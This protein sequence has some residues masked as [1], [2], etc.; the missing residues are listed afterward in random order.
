MTL[1]KLVVLGDGGVG[2]TALTIQVCTQLITPFPVRWWWVALPKSLCGDV[3]SN[4]W[5]LLPK[6]GCNWFAFLYARGIGYGRARRIYGFKRPMDPRWRRICACLQHY[7]SLIVYENTQ[8]SQPDPAGEGVI[9]HQLSHQRRLSFI[10]DLANDGRKLW[11]GAGDVGRK[12]KWPSDGSSGVLSGGEC[13]SQRHGLRFCR[14]I[15]EELHQRRKSILRSGP[16]V[17]TAKAGANTAGQESQ[18]PGGRHG[19]HEHDRFKRPQ[20]KSDAWRP[21]S[22]RGTQETMRDIMI[23]F[24][25]INR[26]SGGRKAFDVMPPFETFPIILREW[27]YPGSLRSFLDMMGQGMKVLTRRSPVQIS[28]RIFGTSLVHFLAN[29]SSIP[30]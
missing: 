27:R 7:L 2:K 6:T 5:G 15:G 3:W 9:E 10:S 19:C 13:I 23:T 30:H 22:K 1:Y 20:I 18:Y 17:T 16:F 12:Q 26:S 21:R 24:N 8:I 14:G 28:C 25:H 4:H 29:N 11:S